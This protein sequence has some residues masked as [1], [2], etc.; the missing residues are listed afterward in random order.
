MGRTRRASGFCAVALLVA[1]GWGWAGST[2]AAGQ[3]GAGSTETLSLTASGERG[4]GKELVITAEGIADGAH[5]LFVFGGK[6]SCQAWPSEEEEG[7]ALAL[8]APGGELLPAGAFTRPFTVI[9]TLGSSYGVCAFLDTSASALRDAWASGCFALSPGPDCRLPELNPA[10]VLT[11]EEYARK[12]LAEE[13]QQRAEREAHEHLLADE[14]A[15]A[16]K[17]R[18]EAKAQ[19]AARCHVPRV[20]GH[21]APAARRMLAAAHCRLGHVTVRKGA[22]KPLRIFWQ[23]PGRGGDYAPGTAVAVRLA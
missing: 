11:A 18:E 4:I 8:T 23:R 12:V 9:P 22:R 5:R 1:S 6:S 19:E 14:A 21:T 2:T 13:E 7:H 20:L 15:Q 16:L 10:A 3:S 17:E